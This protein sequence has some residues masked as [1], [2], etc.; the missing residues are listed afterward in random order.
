MAYEFRLPDIGEGLTEAEVVRWFVQV[1]EE[2][3]LDQPLVQIETDKAVTDVPAPR[4][5]VLLHQG[6]PA[7]ARI[8][9]GQV[10][11]VIGERGEVWARPEAPAQEAAAAVQSPAVVGTLPEAPP[12]PVPAGTGPEPPAPAAEAAP[13]PPA[14]APARPEALPAV[15]RLARELGV[16]LAAVRG[17]GPQG[18]VTRADVERAARAASAAAPTPAVPA[19][20]APAPEERV[21]MSR[22][23]RT[24]AERL[25]RSWREIPHVTTFGQA[26]AGRLLHAQ[27]ALATRRGERLPLETLFVRAVLPALQA[28][29]QFNAAVEGEDLVLKRHYDIGIAVDTPE[30]LIVPVVRNA[31]RLELWALARE[32][33]R[34]IEA[35]R[36]RTATPEELTGATFTISNIGA[37]GGSYG[38]PLIPWGTTAVLS[39][40]RV[41]EQAVVR[42][43][44]IEVA[45]ML[46]L[47]LSYD[48]RAIDGALGRRFLA[49]VVEHLEE[50]A[51]LVG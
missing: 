40:G 48:H 3:K 49:T 8:E 7:G 41:E 2:V 34:L 32:V 16:D 38:T 28:H 23:R 13:R 37:V 5:G 20:A 27:K 15:R 39:F 26:E 22:L 51:L 11:A 42:G 33:A 12:E 6:A 45:A 18:R 30:G 44:R 43:G 25:T 9:V 46:P 17:T 50:P 36:N 14:P 47:S 31:D 29:P 24:I 21:R 1:G 19:E 10:L 35:A 4:A